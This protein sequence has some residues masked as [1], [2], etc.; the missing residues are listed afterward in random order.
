MTWV[1][2]ISMSP[3]TGESPKRWATEAFGYG[4]PRRSMSTWVKPPN[5]IWLVTLPSARV[6]VG[7]FISFAPFA[8][9]MFEALI[10]G[11]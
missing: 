3:L 5:H 6:K 8:M 11:N 9:L 10:S 1:S 4:A 2:C 7:C